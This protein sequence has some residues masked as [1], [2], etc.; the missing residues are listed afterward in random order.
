M[1]R[2]RELAALLLA[3]LAATAAAEPARDGAPAGSGGLFDLGA[4]GSGGKNKE[5]I[6]ITSDRLEYD[7]K[8]D[9]VVYRGDVLAVQGAVKVKSDRLTVTLEK[10]TGPAV[11]GPRPEAATPHTP[12]PGGRGSR[13][14]EVVAVGNVR[15][16]QGTKWA[17]G[18]KA[19]FDQGQRTLVLTETPVMHDGPNE[20]AGDRV[21]V[22]LDEDRS[23]VEGGRKRVKAVLYPG[24]DGGL[25][26]SKPLAPPPVLPGTAAGAP[27]AHAGVDSGP[28]EA[29]TP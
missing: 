21:I 11:A 28:A 18:G 2:R 13:V 19:V 9:I 14:H 27:E 6:T 10:E 16:D 25:A 7:Y 3:A 24:K 20:V 22:F 23:L 26:P 29:A 4:I 8:N 5:P 1:P 12:E 15:I 17:T